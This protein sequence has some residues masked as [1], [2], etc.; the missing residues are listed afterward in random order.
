MLNDAI[1]S[2]QYIVVW[3]VVFGLALCLSIAI[4]EGVRRRWPFVVAATIATAVVGWE[5][6]NDEEALNR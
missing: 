2:V 4:P 3:S 6:M 5:Y 1:R